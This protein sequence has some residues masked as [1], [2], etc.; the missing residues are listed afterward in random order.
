MIAALSGPLT[1]ERTCRH[2]R[3]RYSV[4]I[5]FPL[6]Y[7]TRYIPKYLFF[8]KLPANMNACSL[9]CFRRAGLSGFPASPARRLCICISILSGDNTYYLI[10]FHTG[11]SEYSDSR[12]IFFSLI[13]SK[14]AFT[15][16]SRPTIVILSSAYNR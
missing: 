15:T 9:K 13:L 7:Y 8:N 14:I 3:H 6:R 16:T 12:W 1:F 4:L 5:P 11:L 2:A 10:F